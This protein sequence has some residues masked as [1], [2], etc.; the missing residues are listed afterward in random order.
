M[1][2]LCR[3]LGLVEYEGTGYLG[4]Q[5][6][7]Q[8]PTVQEKL[9]SAATQLFG[10]STWVTVPSRTDA[11]VHARGQVIAFDAPPLPL[12]RVLL[13]L[14]T[15]LPPDIALKDLVL[16]PLDFRVKETK[17]K[18]Y[19]YQIWQ[20]PYPS[21]FRL[22][23][24]WWSTKALDLKALE[25]A[26]QEFVGTH[27]FSAFRGRGCQSTSAL[28]S[29]YQIKLEVTPE[30]NGQILHLVISGD[31]F[32]RNMVRIMVGT[33][34]EIAWGQKP[35]GTVAKALGSGQRSH[36]GQTAPAH[37][38]WLEKVFYDPDPFVTRGLKDWQ[39]DLGQIDPA[40]VSKPFFV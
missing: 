24:H 31:S 18:E 40:L 8:G 3:Y 38:L 33:L 17:G 15:Y 6:Q 27:D 30:I 16:V 29:I 14:N 19:R 23:D 9:V 21:P 10:Q 22:K 1:E 13:G 32:L 12:N 34:V 36:T 25:E 20:S 39:E 26:A 11:G 28:K 2:P 5:V 35:Q 7:P 37:G 4:W